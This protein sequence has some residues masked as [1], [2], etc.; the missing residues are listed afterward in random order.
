MERLL[1]NHLQQAYPLGAE[2][3][4]TPIKAAASFKGL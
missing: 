1:A 4:L 2:L 3:Q